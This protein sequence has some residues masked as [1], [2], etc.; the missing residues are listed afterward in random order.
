MTGLIEMM[1]RP[2]GKASGLICLDICEHKTRERLATA[3]EQLVN[4][5]QPGVR[6]E[7][8]DAQVYWAYAFPE[9]KS[10]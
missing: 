2:A 7:R 3:V 9:P 5:Y 4:T 8:L 1:C 10:A 6:R